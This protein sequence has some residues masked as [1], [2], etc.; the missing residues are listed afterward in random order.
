MNLATF[1]YNND[2]STML[3][4]LTRYLP[5]NCYLNQQGIVLSLLI[6]STRVE[7]IED[8]FINCIYRR[9]APSTSR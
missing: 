1:G 7:E 6:I 3:E 2:F 4:R 9:R 5:V 8:I